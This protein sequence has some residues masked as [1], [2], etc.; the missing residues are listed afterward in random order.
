MI[1]GKFQRWT[2]QV[3]QGWVVPWKNA[4]EF[5]YCPYPLRGTIPSPTQTFQSTSNFH[6]IPIPTKGRNLV[7][8]TTKFLSISTKKLPTS[9]LVIDMCS[10]LKKGCWQ[11]KIEDKWIF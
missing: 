9:T 5:I 11:I 8:Q 7:R 4:E 10:A 6:S 2:L 1:T 3:C